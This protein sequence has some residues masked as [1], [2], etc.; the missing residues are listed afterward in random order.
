MDPVQ[1][2]LSR[3]MYY[4]CKIEPEY[5]ACGVLSREYRAHLSRYQVE[6]R[7]FEY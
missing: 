6:S 5:L 2:L 3:E 4:M 7:N 1:Q